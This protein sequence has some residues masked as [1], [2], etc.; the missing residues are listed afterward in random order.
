MTPIEIPSFEATYDMAFVHAVGNGIMDRYTDPAGNYFRSNLVKHENT[1][2]WIH[3]GE[4][5]NRLSTEGV[6]E[7]DHMDSIAATS[8]KYI[9]NLPEILRYLAE[10]LPARL[11]RLSWQAS[12][13]TPSF[14]NPSQFRGKDKV[15]GDPLFGAPACMLILKLLPVDGRVQVCKAE[16]KPKPKVTHTPAPARTAPT[17]APVEQEEDDDGE[18]QTQ[19]H[20]GTR[21]YRSAVGGGTARAPASTPV[22]AP[23]KGRTK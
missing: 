2:L 4:Q 15:T 22:R 17:S 20:R 14:Y 18:F 7:E 6:P 8:V 1:E 10:K 23:Y 19:Q 3:V 11:D 21:N 16:V 13:L 9:S 12:S 5:L